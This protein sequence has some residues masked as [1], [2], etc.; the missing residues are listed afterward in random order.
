MASVYG[1]VGSLLLLLEKFREKGI[2]NIKSLDDIKHF[3]DSYDNEITRVKEKKQVELTENISIFKIQLDQ[4]SIEYGEKLKIKEEQLLKEKEA[5]SLWLKEYVEKPNNLVYKIINFPKHNLFTKRYSLLSIKFDEEKKKP[6]SELFNQ[7][8]SLKN[9]IVD[10]ENHFDQWV[11][12]LSSSEIRN[13]ENIKMTIE[14]NMQL[15]S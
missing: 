2:N 11:N 14:E 6:F 10:K 4:L 7:I 5:V 3:R 12:K 13:L 15:V 8:E 1:E 9:E